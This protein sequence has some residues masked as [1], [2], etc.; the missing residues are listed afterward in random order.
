VRIALLGGGDGAYTAETQ[1]E[2]IK[3]RILELEN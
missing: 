3:G 2:S 1:G